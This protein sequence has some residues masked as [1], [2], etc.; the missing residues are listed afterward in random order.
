MQQ[1]LK[2]G[3][4][5]PQ[6]QLAA[7]HW[8]SSSMARRVQARCIVRA[9]LFYA[10]EVSTRSLYGPNGPIQRHEVPDSKRMPAS[11]AA[12]LIANAMAAGVAECWLAKQPVLL[13]GEFVTED[14]ISD[15]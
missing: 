6:Q 4:Q 11:R 7:L 12:V 1:V 2:R 9:C 13:M 5:L 10:G 14:W 8:H 15:I 3:A